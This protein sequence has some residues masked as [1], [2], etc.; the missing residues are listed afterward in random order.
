MSLLFASPWIGFAIHGS[1]DTPGLVYGGAIAVIPI[2]MLSA[3]AIR[4]WQVWR[5][6]P[7]ELVDERTNGRVFPPDGA[8]VAEAPA[9]FSRGKLWLELQRNG[10]VVSQSALLT[11]HGV[12]ETT[13]KIHAAEQTGQLWI[14]W[15][16]IV[17][18]CVKSD[19][20]GPDP[21]QL[22]LR[23]GGQITLRRFVPD[24]ATECDLLD[25][26]RSVGGVPV[27]VYCNVECDA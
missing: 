13:L 24:H 23:S 14:D 26:V 3:I 4:R 8:P 19:S 20:D 16:E 27:R 21:Y 18:W 17:E 10:V 1:V 9:R 15:R 6:L 22:R 2:V 5:E 25:A 11:M 12:S 7:R